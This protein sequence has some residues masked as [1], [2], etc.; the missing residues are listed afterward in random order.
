MH[1]RHADGNDLRLRVEQ[2]HALR[3]KEVNDPAERER[4]P[5]RHR[6]AVP[7]AF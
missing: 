2:R 5:Q 6:N 1:H 7:L 3:R 4:D